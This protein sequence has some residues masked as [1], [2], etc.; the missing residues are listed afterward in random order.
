M[1]KKQMFQ[2]VAL[3]NTDMGTQHGD[4]KHGCTKKQ[5]L[6]WKWFPDDLI[7]VL[8]LRRQC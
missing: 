7:D 5:Q 1:I 4:K 2:I 3:N 8:Q 6:L